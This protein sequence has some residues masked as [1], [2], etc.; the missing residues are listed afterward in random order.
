MVLIEKKLKAK[1][2]QSKQHT[3]IIFFF[4]NFFSQAAHMYLQ[5]FYIHTTFNTCQ[6]EIFQLK[7][8]QRK[9]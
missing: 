4:W 7:N 9:Y 8:I 1:I 2:V 6:I 3:I 5:W